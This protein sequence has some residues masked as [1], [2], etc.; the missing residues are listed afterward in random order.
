MFSLRQLIICAF[1]LACALVTPAFAQDKSSTQTLRIEGVVMDQSG[2]AVAWAQISVMIAPNVF[3]QS[4]TDG[5]GRFA[6]YIEPAREVVLIVRAMGFAGTT[7]RVDTKG[8]ALTRIE[9]VLAPAPLAFDV[10]VTA[11]RTEKLLGDTPSSVV[12]LSTAELSTTAAVTLD[13]ALRQ[14]PGFTLF[15]RSGSRTANP[16]T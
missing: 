14:V 7:K 3:K 12:M 6:F 11:T 5:Y 16:T 15:R 1:V 4:G 2:A 13:D 9:I 10:A 8:L